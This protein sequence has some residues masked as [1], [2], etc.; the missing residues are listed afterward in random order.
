MAPLVKYIIKVHVKL[1]IF[2]Q[3]REKNRFIET[4]TPMFQLIKAFRSLN[5][6]FIKIRTFE[7]INKLVSKQKRVVCLLFLF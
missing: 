3:Q 6:T 7:L 5:L 2:I 1:G 4:Q